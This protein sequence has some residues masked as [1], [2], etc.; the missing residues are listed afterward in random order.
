MAVVAANLESDVQLSLVSTHAQLVAVPATEAV[1]L[2]EV[3]ATT[4]FLANVSVVKP[5]FYAIGA[6]LIAGLSTWFLA[7]AELTGLQVCS[8]HRAQ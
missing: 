4:A 5:V 3:D 6:A 8:Q 1:H 7:I 2:P